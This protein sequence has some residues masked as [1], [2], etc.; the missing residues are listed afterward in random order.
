MASA[1][2]FSK[3]VETKKGYQ[4]HNPNDDRRG[5]IVP[6][7]DTS[8][9][10][11]SVVD[12]AQAA[13]GARYAK[14]PK[15][16]YDDSGNIVDYDMGSLKGTKIGDFLKS[17]RPVPVNPITGPRSDNSSNP[18]ADAIATSRAN[19]NTGPGVLRQMLTS[20]QGNP[21]D[22]GSA[23]SVDNTPVASQKQ[24]NL[25]PTV[26]NG[27]STDPANVPLPQPRPDYSQPTALDPASIEQLRQSLLTQAGQLDPNNPNGLS[28]RM[29]SPMA[30]PDMGT[31]RNDAMSI[32]DSLRGFDGSPKP[33][34]MSS[35]TSG[36][37]PD[38]STPVE[39]VSALPDLLSSIL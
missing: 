39:G 27:V 20:L 19:G 3:L 38:T 13:A 16:I 36:S 1:N 2:P 7:E 4:G 31:Q 22:V 14:D 23:I 28:G 8:K 25:A 5:E 29:N 37:L 18:F 9:N 10:D 12:P 17:I 6:L 32:E 24:A 34:D 26:D 30:Q 21:T 15:N 11:R 33:H 35:V